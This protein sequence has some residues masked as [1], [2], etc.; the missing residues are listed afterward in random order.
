MK[1]WVSKLDLTQYYNDA[2]CIFYTCS[3]IVFKGANTSTNSSDHL[4]N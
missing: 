1:V 3:F 2:L 4:G